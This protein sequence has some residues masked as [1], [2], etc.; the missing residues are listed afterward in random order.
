M[1]FG[2]FAFD[3]MHVLFINCVGYLLDTILDTMKPAKLKQL[4][5]RVKNYTS[6]RRANGIK[7]PVVRKLSSTAYLTAEKKVV[8]L[9]MWSHALGSKAL[10]LSA[11]IRRDALIAVSSLQ[12]IVHSVRRLRPFTRSEHRYLF[13]HIGRRFFSALARIQ[14]S[15]RLQRIEAAEN[16]N[17]GKPPA[18]RRRVP[19]WKAAAKLSDESPNTVDSTDKDEPPYFLRSGKII[20][21]SFV[22]FPEQVFLGGSH[23]FHDTAAQESHHPKSIGL[24]GARARTYSDRNKS[25][26]KMMHF[27]N[28]LR[29]LQEICVQARLDD[30]PQGLMYVMHDMYPRHN[31]CLPRH[32]I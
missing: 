18:K 2:L 28:D 19:Y 30:D 16:F 32:N 12:I 3:M 29:L 15:K 24:S 31:I 21:H 7:S 4:D 23:S 13:H 11:D 9:F 10:I 5:R 8:S 26:L 6:F 27:N 17:I 25:A 22:H 14:H 20:P 1:Y